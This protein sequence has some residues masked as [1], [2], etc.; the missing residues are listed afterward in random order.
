MTK[1]II[2]PSKI[3][4]RRDFINFIYCYLAAILL[5][6][7]LDAFDRKSPNYF[8]SLLLELLV[9]GFPAIVQL[10]FIYFI[11]FLITYYCI[12]QIKNG[13]LRTIFLILF[14]ISFSLLVGMITWQYSKPLYHS[15]NE[16][17]KDSNTYL[18]F[19]FISVVQVGILFSSKTYWQSQAS[20]Q[21][22]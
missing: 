13:Y 1:F 19:T 16:Y 12:N 6:T 3:L 17:L 22:G 18:I 21:A 11:Y 15:L 20:H 2:R 5:V 14:A 8:F 10:V 7:L 9:L 4:R